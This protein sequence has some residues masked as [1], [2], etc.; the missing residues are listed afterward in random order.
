MPYKDRDAEQANKRKRNATYYA[1]NRERLIADACERQRADPAAAAKRAAKWRR[2]NLATD[3]ATRAR[4]R[5]EQANR[6]PAW[7]NLDAI[8][9]IYA[10]A[11]AQ[12]LEVDHVIPL[13]GRN[14]SGLHVETNLQLLSRPDNIRKGNRYEVEAP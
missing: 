5:A 12:G 8:R 4:R 13:R 11:A 6:T 2:G 14:V 7:A 1:K 9:T 3:A 10:A